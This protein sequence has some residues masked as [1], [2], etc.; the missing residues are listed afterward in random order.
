MSKPIPPFK[1]G[2]DQAIKEFGTHVALAHALG[3]NDLRNI[4]PWANG[5]R[6][7][8]PEHCLTIERKSEG[9][10]TRQVLRPHDF[11]KI[12]PDLAHLAPTVPAEAGVDQ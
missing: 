12:W 6:P 3:Y 10:V 8:T 1:A 11:W 5:V 4:S 9:R 7:F 2:A